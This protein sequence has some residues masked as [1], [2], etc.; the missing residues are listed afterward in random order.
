MDMMATAFD[1]LFRYTVN[2]LKL[3]RPRNWHTIKFTNAQFKA[4][5]DC[6]IG[7]RNIL[8][9]MGY[10][11]PV[12]GEDG[13]QNGLSYPDPS[14]IVQDYI[15]LIAAELLIAKTEIKLA[16]ES[17]IRLD[18][19]SL[20]GP[21]NVQLENPNPVQERPPYHHN[22]GDEMY[23]SN[24][25]PSYGP[26][27]TSS[28]QFPSQ[29]LVS[30]VHIGPH[31]PS[32]YGPIPP[33]D[34]SSQYYRTP[35]SSHTSEDSY[36]TNPSQGSM[37]PSLQ[38]HQSFQ[39]PN[40]YAHSN[41]SQPLSNQHHGAQ[42]GHQYDHQLRGQGSQQHDYQF[43]QDYHSSQDMVVEDVE[44]ISSTSAYGGDTND[45]SAKLEEL[46]RKKADIWK[47]FDP[48]TPSTG[49]GS[50]LNPPVVSQP[51]TKPRSAM[52]TPIAVLGEQPRA[53]G[54]QPPV[55]KP[56]R[57]RQPPANPPPSI[58]EDESLP[59][60]TSD[61][62][63]ST[64]QG[65]PPQ[66]PQA[67]PRKVRT[68]MECDMCEFYNHEKSMECMECGNPKNERWRKIQMPGK[69]AGILPSQEPK[70]SPQPAE[71]VPV[72]QASIPPSSDSS[73]EAPSN[74]HYD[75][76]PPSNMPA[77]VNNT[78]YRN[79][80]DVTAQLNNLPTTTGHY[81]NQPNTVAWHDN[82]ATA[83]AAAAPSGA[84]GGSDGSTG[85]ISQG[86][87]PPPKYYTAEE[88]RILQLEAKK[89]KEAKEGQQQQHR[90]P[91]EQGGAFQN[92]M[93]RNNNYISDPQQ[94]GGL[95][96]PIGKVCPDTSNDSDSQFYKNLGLQGQYLICD[97][98]VRVLLI[99]HVLIF[100]FLWM[101]MIFK[102]C[103]C[104]CVHLAVYCL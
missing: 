104:S 52:T 85:I 49:S 6:M 82:Q 67:A 17:H 58:K 22:L 94:K 53:S 36:H 75:S 87:L 12:T 69:P 60:G 96:R 63:L 27:Q 28:R 100:Y 102:Y 62:A 13:K 64:N 43:S 77:A 97:I 57:S 48:Q 37:D 35:P 44:S 89:E 14:Q 81:N 47:Y 95:N 72:S 50:N 73:R 34:F 31:D 88:K 78:Q 68:M 42:S 1:V 32:R 41:I 99:L 25:N 23:T 55:P 8:N 40:S 54:G 56:R 24:V 15:K 11:Q 90:D 19:S 38:H 66:R 59:S 5:A 79:P 76:Q 103:C 26:P 80:P 86:Y 65:G 61:V 33:G 91:V 70:V 39:H 3:K 46:K 74:V 98:K 45:M 10:T 71:T 29:Q 2:M 51:Q 4:R 92:F 18:L 21:Y 101:K 84:T 30:N 9:I 20:P 7:T 83:A 93:P 16:Q